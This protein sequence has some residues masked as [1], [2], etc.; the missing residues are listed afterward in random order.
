MI[1]RLR[2]KLKFRNE[3]AQTTVSTEMLQVRQDVENLEL[4]KATG[5][6]KSKHDYSRFAAALLTNLAAAFRIPIIPQTLCGTS[7]TGFRA[8]IRYF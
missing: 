2:L 6:A 8:H 3:G 7:N 4:Q 1:L 5:Q